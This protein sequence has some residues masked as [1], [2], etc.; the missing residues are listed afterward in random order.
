[1]KCCLC[2]MSLCHKDGRTM[3]GQPVD[4]VIAPGHKARGDF[5]A[6][7]R[8][9]DTDVTEL[10]YSDNLLSPSGVIAAAQK[11]IAEILGSVIAQQMYKCFAKSRFSVSCGTSIKDKTSFLLCVPCQ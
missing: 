3:D 10:S 11:D 7:F 8:T 1:M 2:M 9:A 5:K 4:F 6:K